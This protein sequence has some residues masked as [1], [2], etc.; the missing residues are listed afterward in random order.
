V[1][2]KQGILV[3]AVSHK[4]RFVPFEVVLAD[5]RAVMRRRR[6]EARVERPAELA[7]S[8]KAATLGDF[9]QGSLVVVVVCQHEPQSLVEPALQQ[10]GANPAFRRQEP[11][12]RR[13]REMG[14]IGDLVGPEV[15]VRKVRVDVIQRGFISSTSRDSFHRPPALR[16]R[17]RS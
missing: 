13:A 5:E 15:L 1:P 8:A 7:R 6:T 10:H 11:V 17:R 2:P 3:E 16:A 12:E 14:S 4:P 9:L